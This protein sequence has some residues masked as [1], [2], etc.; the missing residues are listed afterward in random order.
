[1][2]IHKLSLQKK[3]L[4][5]EMVSLLGCPLACESTIWHPLKSQPT[6][7]FRQETSEEEEAPVGSLDQG[8]DRGSGDREE[9]D[10][11]GQ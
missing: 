5:P 8:H 9:E 7:D 11:R 3:R 10:Q 6:S 1:M 4:I 2:S